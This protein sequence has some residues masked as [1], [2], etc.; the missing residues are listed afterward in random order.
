MPEFLQKIGFHEAVVR[1]LAQVLR[2]SPQLAS[3][4]CRLLQRNRGY[5]DCPS[6]LRMMKMLTDEETRRL[7][8][9]ARVARLGCIVSGEPYVVPINFD[10]EGDYL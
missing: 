7:F 8:Q 2:E 6:P 1:N 4:K 5:D 9:F 3:S 10:L